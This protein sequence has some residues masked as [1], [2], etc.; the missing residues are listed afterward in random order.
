MPSYIPDD[1]LNADIARK[2]YELAS[3]EG[4]GE[5]LTA[6]Y[7]EQ[8]TFHRLVGVN[9]D[10]G[11]EPEK[12]KRVT[13]QG[14]QRFISGLAT[15]PSRIF[16]RVFTVVGGQI[17]MEMAVQHDRQ[18]D[19]LNG[20]LDGFL[21]GVT[22]TAG[23]SELPKVKYAGCVTGIPG[24]QSAESTEQIP[25]LD[26]L[27]N[28]ISGALG[29]TF[30]LT[31]VAELLPRKALRKAEQAIWSELDEAAKQR[32][33][34][35][36]Q[37]DQHSKTTTTSSS[38]GISDVTGA[39]AVV[40]NRSSST[41]TQ[42]TES[43]TSGETQSE[44]YTFT[45]ES[46]GAH[47]V[48]EHFQRD[49]QRIRQAALEGGWAVQIMFGVGSASAVYK[50]GALI[51]GALVGQGTTSRALNWQ[52]NS[53]VLAWLEA[54]WQLPSQ[55]AHD[56]LLSH[57][58][59]VFC[60]SRE[61]SELVALPDRNYPG[62]RQIPLPEFSVHVADGG[63]VLGE[64]CFQGKPLPGTRAGFDP[65]QLVT[66]GLV[67]GMTGSGKTN[68]LFRIL[69]ELTVP[70][71]VIEPVKTEYRGLLT[72]F[73]NL[74]IYTLGD[75]RI[76][77]LRL[78][79]FW[80]P[81]GFA[82]QHHIDSL[83]ALFSA[84]FTMYASMPNILEQCLYN[85]Y[86]KKGWSLQHSTNVY[87][88]AGDIGMEFYPT[89]SDL[90]QEIDTYLTL[91]GYAEEQKQNLRSALLTRLK[92]LMSGGKGLL[93]NTSDMTPFSELFDKPVVMELDGIPDDDEKALVIGLLL[94]RIYEHL[95]MAQRNESEDLRHLLVIEEAHRV[96]RNVE[97]SNNP[98]VANPLGKMVEMFSNMMA[99]IRAYGQGI[100]IVEQIPTKLAPDA[101]KNTG[102]KIVH[103]LVSRDD[104]DYMSTALGITQEEAQYCSHLERGYALLFGEGMH[105]P[106]LVCVA[107]AKLHAQLPSLQELRKAAENFNAQLRRSEGKYPLVEVVAQ[108]DYA[109]GIA[110]G[111]ASRLT[112]NLLYDSAEQFHPAITEAQQQIIRAIAACGYD[113]PLDSELQF[114]TSLLHACLC[115]ISRANPLLVNNLRVTAFLSTYLDRALIFANRPFAEDEKTLR[116]LET[117]RNTDLHDTL[118]RAYTAT[119]QIKPD[120]RA[121]ITGLP[122]HPVDGDAAIILAR[123]GIPGVLDIL[124][125]QQTDLAGLVAAVGQRVVQEF[126]IRPAHAA[127]I[128]WLTAKIILRLFAGRP[129]PDLPTQ[130]IALLHLAPTPADC[131]RQPL[132]V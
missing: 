128:A 97:A 3:P 25:P 27:D 26:F 67:V 94:I 71:M 32:S 58:Q 9:I 90:H 107:L 50:L 87:A 13:Q 82:L 85:I 29:E 127:P 30:N 68:T 49:A 81:Y 115:R 60:T 126:I 125:E 24:V 104:C 64:A 59:R 112:L 73:P 114:A 17:A 62:F 116:Q 34:S 113:I 111:I 53:K 23:I 102:L 79:P 117:T 105:R 55:Q 21:P 61:L 6:T 91:S 43:I 16:F 37:S 41:S 2:L 51:T 86:T 20:G 14:M 122:S 101:V 57:P 109:M 22:T 74:R 7:T 39:G 129:A 83:K 100:I 78:N 98:E 131:S 28:I 66:H 110:T 124:P 70:F 44:G 15:I 45:L 80:F 121:F 93:L 103:R 12:R 118:V 1:A 11:M 120:Y 10:P 99:E 69:H 89:L 8:P 76:S 4:I 48:Y 119:M 35:Q 77:P 106:T 42:Q 31:I 46:S 132:E 96:F 36:Q 19:L 65:S 33:V 123:W 52:L 18:C 95:K 5:T 72:S 84:S 130:M 47:A 40:V 75:E 56:Q 88:G 38:E 54:P 108:D 92:S 63:L